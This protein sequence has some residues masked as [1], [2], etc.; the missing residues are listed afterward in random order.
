MRRFLG[1][2]QGED[3]DANVDAADKASS[4]QHDGSASEPPPPL[5]D[6]A[7]ERVL[8]GEILDF[9]PIFLDRAHRADEG[10]LLRSRF[11]SRR[12][13]WCHRS[14]AMTVSESSHWP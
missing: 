4:D 10:W 11:R 3:P 2:Q 8:R 13:V 9:W 12:I 5:L 1:E 14:A 7:A 6:A